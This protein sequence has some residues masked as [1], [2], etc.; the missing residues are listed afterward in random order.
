M[1]SSIPPSSPHG[2]RSE[3]NPNDLSLTAEQKDN[4]TKL[5]DQLK[6][7]E[8]EAGY[9]FQHVD[10]IAGALENLDPLHNSFLSSINKDENRGHVMCIKDKFQPLHHRFLKDLSEI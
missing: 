6:D 10:R 7:L 3:I 9:A 8:Q 4:L 2:F 5:L 1:V